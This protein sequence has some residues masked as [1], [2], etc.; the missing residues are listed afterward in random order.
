MIAAQ[1]I[2]DLFSIVGHE[3]RSTRVDCGRKDDPEHRFFETVLPA[4]AQRKLAALGAFSMALRTYG[5]GEAITKQT[6]Q[7]A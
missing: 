5:P 2:S 4:M 7:H 6:W 3:I 1:T